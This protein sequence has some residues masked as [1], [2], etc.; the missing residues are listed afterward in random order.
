MC[1]DESFNGGNRLEKKDFSVVIKM[2]IRR[3]Q[4][5]QHSRRVKG[6]QTSST[7]NPD[8]FH[9]IQ[10]YC[11]EVNSIQYES[12]YVYYIQTKC[13]KPLAMLITSSFIQ[14]EFSSWLFLSFHFSDAYYRIFL[15]KALI[16][17]CL[18]MNNNCCPTA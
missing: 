15:L 17:P 1:S 6:R 9:L 12:N 10:I 18:K 3:R 2:T 16:I 14:I 13:Y 5:D 4:H 8:I 11:Y 7:L